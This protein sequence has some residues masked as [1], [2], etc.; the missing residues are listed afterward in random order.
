MRCEHFSFRLEVWLYD[1]AEVKKDHTVIRLRLKT[2]RRQQIDSFGKLT[3]SYIKLQ[4][5]TGQG[6]AGQSSSIR[7]SLA[8]CL[9]GSYP[10]R[11]V[12]TVKMNYTPAKPVKLDDLTDN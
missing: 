6:R 9:Q 1:P 10:V 7:L 11:T 12:C 5:R 4:G 3:L 2:P 8:A